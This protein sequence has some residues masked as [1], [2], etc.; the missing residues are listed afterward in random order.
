VNG[1][2]CV[3]I[4]RQGL[5]QHVTGISLG[6]R[7]LMVAVKNIAR[8]LG[9]DISEAK[10][11]LDSRLPDGSRVA[12][13]IPPCSLRGVTLTIRKFSRRH[14]EMQDLIA[15]GTLDQPLANRLED[16]VLSR[17]NILI[18]GGTGSGKTTLLNALGRFIP[19]DE[20]ILLIEDTAEIRMVHT[21]LV[22]FEARQAQNGLSAVAIR[23]LLKA[24]LRHRPDRII[25]GEIRGGEAF[26]LLQLLNTGHSGTLSTIHASSAKQG[27]AR[28]TSCVLQSGIE[29]PYRAIKTNIGDSLN[30]VIHVERRPG[31]RFISEV[32]E[33]NSYDPDADLFDYGAI[34]Q[35][36]EAQ[37]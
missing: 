21:N 33:I 14:F 8:R 23:D 6:E 30:V 2:D 13:V 9:D 19:E 31:R 10:P 32:L 1:A 28:F 3:F 37:P 22:R 27:L 11:I 4:E 16:Y 26:D 36:P 5:L 7:A 12:A 29:L 24:S 18:S 25:L 34:Y 20:R 15:A 17:K 35:R